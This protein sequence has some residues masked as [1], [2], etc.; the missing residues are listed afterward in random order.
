M[1]N[2][3]RNLLSDWASCLENLQRQPFTSILYLMQ[4]ANVVAMTTR[5]ALLACSRSARCS[6]L[7]SH[8]QSARTQ[9]P[10]GTAMFA[11]RLVQAITQC[12]EWRKFL[13]AVEVGKLYLSN[14]LMSGLLAALH[15]FEY[16][17]KHA[18]PALTE[19]HK[20]RHPLGVGIR[21]V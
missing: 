14:D 5:S 21:T 11:L 4:S 19:S 3:R 8:S 15:I 18:C 20:C 6:R 13:N 17:I 9:P 1:T 16:F 12:C 2:C 10:N 7:I